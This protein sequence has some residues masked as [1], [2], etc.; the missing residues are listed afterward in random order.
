VEPPDRGWAI[1]NHLRTNSCWMPQIAFTGGSPGRFITRTGL[2]VLLQFE[3][4]CRQ[5]SI[6]LNEIIEL[7]RQRDVRALFAALETG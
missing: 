6:N 4:Q 7:L 3:K 1:N 5:A 2:S